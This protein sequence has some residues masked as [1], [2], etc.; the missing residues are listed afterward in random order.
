M[1][2]KFFTSIPAYIE[3]L[4]VFYSI[5][6]DRLSSSCV[7]SNRCALKMIDGVLD[8][9]TDL[10][11][12]ITNKWIFFVVIDTFLRF[13]RYSHSYERGKKF[14]NGSKDVC[15]CMLEPIEISFVYV[16]FFEISFTIAR[17]QP[18]CVANRIFRFFI[19]KDRLRNEPSKRNTF[20]AEISTR[21]TSWVVFGAQ[22]EIQTVGGGEG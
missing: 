16:N 14:L 13:I 4:Y 11:K 18:R 20:S 12:R 3:Y 15:F 19:R 8:S 2:C 22:I 7:S 5:I 6:D 17:E 1:D 10:S 9:N 21:V